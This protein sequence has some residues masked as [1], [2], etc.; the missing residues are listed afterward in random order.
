MKLLADCRIVNGELQLKKRSTFTSDCRKLRDG[1][2]V[3]TIER[4][5]KK[6]SLNQNGF[7]WGV[8]V[9]LVK[10]GMNDVGYRM[11]TES[12]HEFLK[13]NF[14]IV[15]IVN[16]K[17]GEILKCVGSTTQMTTSQMGEYFDK[18]IQWA[19]EYLNVQIP[20]P[21]EQIQIEFN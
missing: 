8:V 7:Y 9:P 12:T 4:Q 5:G 16:E 13:G 6:R 10:E 20:Y 2:Y 3:L 17:N 15:E 18:I 1:D 11:T 14:N 21:N 19:A